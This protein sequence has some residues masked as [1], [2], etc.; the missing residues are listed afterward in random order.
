MDREQCYNR[1]QLPRQHDSRARRPA[2][3]VHSESPSATKEKNHDQRLHPQSIISR[4]QP[5]TSPRRDAR[6]RSPA[7][8]D[9]P[10][11]L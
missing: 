2:I 7:T 1:N 10:E 3:E 6:S 8:L 5:P 11:R 4:T 9:F